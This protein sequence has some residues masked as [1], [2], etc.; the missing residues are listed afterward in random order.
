MEFNNDLTKFDDEG[1]S[2]AFDAEVY[3][4][5]NYIHGRS[6]KEGYKIVFNGANHFLR[7][8][9]AKTFTMSFSQFFSDG[10][11]DLA[12]A[13]WGVIFGY[14]ED[15]RFGYGIHVKHLFTGKTVLDIYSAVDGRDRKVLTSRTFEVDLRSDG[16][17]QCRLMVETD[18]TTFSIDGCEI[19]AP[20]TAFSGRT[21]FWRGDA[22]K[23]LVIRDLYYHTEENYP[24]ETVMQETTFIIPRDNGN[25]LPYELVLSAEKI[26]GY[27]KLKYTL[28]GSY[29]KRGPSR[30]VG[31]VWLFMFDDLTAPFIRIG[32]GK[33]LYIENGSV[34]FSDNNY[35]N[36]PLRNE[37][38]AVYKKIYNVVEKPLT[39]E[40]YLDEFPLDAT[41]SFG[42]KDLISVGADICSGSREFVFD[43]FGKLIS[44]GGPC[45]EEFT[46]TVSTPA[47]ERI[48]KF[49]IERCEEKEAAIEHLCGNH[50]FD[51][52]K[53][54]YFDVFV[55]SAHDCDLLSVETEIKDAFLLKTLRKI[56]PV[57]TES[58][59]R[60][61]TQ[62]LPVGVYHLAVTLYY[63]GR[64]VKEHFSAF[65]VLDPDCVL[66]PQ[67]ES[68]LPTLYISDGAPVNF[69]TSV[70]DPWSVK[71]D[72]N[73]N[74]Y[75]AV[76]HFLPVRADEVRAWELLRLYNKKLLV[77]CTQRAID[78]DD[79]L[80]GDIEKME[81]LKHAD[82]INYGYPGIEESRLYYRYDYYEKEVYDG[83]LRGILQ[84]FL[85]ENPAVCEELGF[86]DVTKEFTEEMHVT[87]LKKCFSRWIDFANAEIKKLFIEQWSR[88]KK[89]NPH[90][91][92]QSYGPWNAY[93]S[94]LMGA[95][96]SK[97]FGGDPEKWNEIIDGS[98]QF[99]DYPFVCG[100]SSTRGAWGIATQSFM[101]PKLVVY[102]EIYDGFR[103]GCPDGFVSCGTPPLGEYR[104]P[105]Y[106][107]TTQISE[108]VFNTAYLKNGEYGFWRNRGFMLMSVFT[109]DPV[110]KYENI[111]RSWGVIRENF[112]LKPIGAVAFVYE[113]N[114]NEDRVD[115]S[116][117]KHAIYNVSDCNEAYFYKVL[118]ESGCGSAVVTDFESLS[119]ES[120][121]FAA[122][123]L[124]SLDGI[125]AETEKL[126]R[127]LHEKG[128]PLFSVGDVGNLGDVFG[129]KRARDKMQVSRLVYGNRSE[130]ITLTEAE[131]FNEIMDAETV[132]EV[133]GRP[134]ITRKGR[135]FH[136]DA[137]AC[138]VGVD[139][140]RR[141]PYQSRNNISVLLFDAVADCFKNS[142]K[143]EFVCNDGCGL[144]HFVTENG[145][146]DLLIVDYSDLQHSYTDG[147]EK[148]VTVYLSSCEVKD[149]TDLVLG[150]SADL[151]KVYDSGYL[152]A[153]TVKL[154]PRQ[155]CLLRVSR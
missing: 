2:Y 39:G 89:L 111:L 12:D 120:E 121:N 77:W 37:T 144:T 61:K 154:N 91:K 54:F 86:F 108:Y 10:F 44:K 115:L 74:H 78:R 8:P 59:Y 123:V 21:G 87:I 132:I 56:D 76:S 90:A 133:D 97:W 72:M 64:K 31:D 51:C 68:G 129:M 35:E 66:S 17:R 84:K 69:R 49:I 96:N 24:V 119:R 47:N 28:G 30:A 11:C 152:K 79:Y 94:V 41:F 5:Y 46:I 14:D 23:E 81:V 6:T 142:L 125:S 110:A 107:E 83:A 9:M 25:D 85:D 40:F 55:S 138:Q 143:R 139:N 80:S 102:P 48:K 75:H 114:E 62:G 38:E 93:Q 82:F 95:Y 100:Y 20:L 7:L 33:R 124:P 151:C 65:E 36:V 131:F 42:F 112:P 127:R 16:V 103:S 118:R 98:Y 99:E 88:I 136:I 104:C 45:D 148:V 153:F 67:M 19:C 57:R 116:F 155:S 149:V 3:S 1:R 73:V 32:D 60:V 50:Y 70:Q 146:E 105:K 52:G 29:L 13:D 122:V 34:R 43:R 134:L 18:K 22:F 130:R 109:T 137:S 140:Y 92:R 15:T 101:C 26:G 145:N 53:D 27:Y 117:D 126:I 128:M 150:E 113:M 135:A 147:Y 106:L 58:G 141:L 63:C 71:A 4:P